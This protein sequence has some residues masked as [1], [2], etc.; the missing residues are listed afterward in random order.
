M[1][2]RGAEGIIDILQP[3]GFNAVNVPHTHDEGGFEG[4]SS[5]IIL[6]A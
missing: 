1:P 3:L 6:Y 5:G 4:P 2:G